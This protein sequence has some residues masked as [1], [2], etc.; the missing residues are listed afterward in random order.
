MPR[1]VRLGLWCLICATPLLTSNIAT[2]KKP[3]EPPAAPIPVQI[4]TAKKVFISYGV[5]DADPGAPNLTYNEFYALMKDWGK[6]ELTR[7]PADADL[8]FEIRFVSGITDAQLL[9]TIVDPKTHVVLWPL[10]QHVEHSS[11]ESA[12]RKRFDDAM[13]DLIGDLKQLTSQG[14]GQ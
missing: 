1:I 11:R 12:R 8:V 5:G 14:P 4:T 7:A 9:L 2:A 13:E 6:F 3:D 10:V